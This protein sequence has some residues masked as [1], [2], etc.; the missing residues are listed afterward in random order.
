MFNTDFDTDPDPQRDENANLT[1]FFYIWS[2]SQEVVGWP[3][4]KED[5]RTVV[6]YGLFINGMFLA[7]FSF[8]G[9]ETDKLSLKQV[10]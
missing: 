1:L 7:S 6:M 4:N 5:E 10:L 3:Y 8:R 9:A 2:Q